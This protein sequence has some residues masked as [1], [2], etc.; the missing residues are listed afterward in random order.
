MFR[1]LVA[2]LRKKAAEYSDAFRLGVMLSLVHGTGAYGFLKDNRAFADFDKVAMGLV[3]VGVTLGLGITV[4]AKFKNQT[5]DTDAQNA[6]GQAQSA[7]SDLAGWL[8]IIVIVI[9][10]AVILGYLKMMRQSGG[11]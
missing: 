5:T 3:V 6:V 4:L 1:K 8:G 11:R 9:V 7:I 2:K 10:A